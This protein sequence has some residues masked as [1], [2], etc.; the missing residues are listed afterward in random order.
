MLSLTIE[1]SD[2]TTHK[3]FTTEGTE[4]TENRDRIVLRA[5]TGDP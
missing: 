5:K 3:G 4:A 2:A 1:P